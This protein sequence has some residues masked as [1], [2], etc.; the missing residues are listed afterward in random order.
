MKKTI[1]LFIILTQ[2]ALAQPGTL[3][4]SF[5]SN[6]VLSENISDIAIQTDGKIII[7]GMLN[8]EVLARLNTD[9]TLDTGFTPLPVWSTLGQWNWVNKTAIQSDGKIIFSGSFSGVNKLVRLNN[10]GTLDTSFNNIVTDG[11]I[12]KI[13]QQSDGKIIIAGYFTLVNNVSKKG[14]ARLNI[15]GS[16]DTSFNIGMG[17]DRGVETFT[18]QTDGKII[19]GGDFSI[20]NNIARKRIARLNN[21]GS[22]DTSFDPGAGANFMIYTISNQMDGKIIVGGFFTLFGGLEKNKIVRLNSDGSLDST[23]NSTTGPGSSNN[24]TVYTTSIQSDGKIIIGGSFAIFNGIS[25]NNIARLNADG[26]LDTSFDIGTGTGGD[27]KKTLIQTDEK[28]I[29]LGGFTRYNG[30]VR[31]FIARINGATLNVNQYNSQVLKSYP[32]PANT[33]ILLQ[34]PN[35]TSLDKIIITDIM[36]KVTLEQTTNTNQVNVEKLASGLYLIK[37]FS[38]KEQFTSKFI[39]E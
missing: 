27:I 32:N 15:D 14:I 7:S 10:D 8:S 9:G 25:S 39:K 6:L 16:L 37:G 29:I 28:I 19:V 36:G 1:F 20:F 18:I 12:Y 13:I 5:E 24:D 31:I 4:T 26:S 33:I 17:S 35:N 22:L 38:G 21:D 3:D 11:D 23:F 2:L 34:V 30:I